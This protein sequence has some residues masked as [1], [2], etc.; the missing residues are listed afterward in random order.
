MNVVE[1]SNDGVIEEVLKQ[2]EE[3]K[4]AFQEDEQFEVYCKDR[5]HLCTYMDCTA[6]VLQRVI[7]I[8]KEKVGV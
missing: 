7:E 2:I 5:G 6:C 8:I 1:R 3:L 4:N